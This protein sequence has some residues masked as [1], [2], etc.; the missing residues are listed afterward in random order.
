[1]TETPKDSE[2]THKPASLAQLAGVIAKRVQIVSVQL[3]ESQLSRHVRRNADIPSS[4]NLSYG[5]KVDYEFSPTE[6]GLDVSIAY[7][8]E[9]RKA[10]PESE[11]ESFDK[12]QDPEQPDVFEIQGMMAV[13]YKLRDLDGVEEQHVEAFARM[14]GIYNTWPYWREYV[15]SAVG[16]M[17]LPPVTLPVMAQATIE[18]MCRRMDEEKVEKEK[19]QE[20]DKQED[21]SKSK[22]KPTE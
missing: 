6:K 9:G 5:I 1:M 20:Q 8:V 22:S 17:G 16:R 13:E 21:D 19:Q 15:Q 2:K 18:M 4:L 14:N 10:Q 3:M 12:T 11:G 7:R